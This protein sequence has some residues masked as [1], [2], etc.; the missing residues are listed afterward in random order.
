M[1]GD[2]D[3]LTTIWLFH[4]LPDPAWTAVNWAEIAEHLSNIVELQKLCQ[5]NLV[6]VHHGHPVLN[7]QDTLGK[8]PLGR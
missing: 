1:V 8:L 2:Y 4:C 6:A 3:L 5:Q 7:W